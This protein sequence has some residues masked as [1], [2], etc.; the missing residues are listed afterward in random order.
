[1]E[2]G[3]VHGIKA[4]RRFI[5]KQGLRTM[6]KSNPLYNELLTSSSSS[7]FYDHLKKR[8]I[9]YLGDELHSKSTAIPR[10]F[11]SESVVTSF[12]N[13]LSY[14]LHDGKKESFEELEAY[15]D[16]TIDPLLA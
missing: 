12:L 16:A 1:M 7:L 13:I 3:T 10:S 9:G 8:L 5:K 4:T 11:L 2:N 6:G 14:W 15:C